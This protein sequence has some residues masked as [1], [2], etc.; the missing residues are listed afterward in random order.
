MDK[1]VKFVAALSLF[2]LAINSFRMV[3]NFE[4]MVDLLQAL[5]NSN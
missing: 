4:M 3:A 5:V 1:I 2:V